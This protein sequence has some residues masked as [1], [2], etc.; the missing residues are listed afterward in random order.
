MLADAVLRGEGD[1]VK[2]SELSPTARDAAVRMIREGLAPE[3]VVDFIYNL[4]YMA[5][6]L[7]FANIGTKRIQDEVEAQKVAA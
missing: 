5:G 1:K 7:D 6:G 2:R 4:G 3:K